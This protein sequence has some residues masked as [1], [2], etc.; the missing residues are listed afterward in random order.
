MLCT[1]YKNCY[2]KIFIDDLLYRMIHWFIPVP[3]HYHWLLTTGDVI[4]L[5]IG[6]LFFIQNFF[7]II[8][9][10]LG[11]KIKDFVLFFCFNFFQRKKILISLLIIKTQL[12]EKNKLSSIHPF[13][14]F[15]MCV[16]AKRIPYDADVLTHTHFSFL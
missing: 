14:S 16:C 9:G 10:Y 3:H 6:N 11:N 1:E 15:R 2:F 8:Q 7:K 4:I 13:Y 12:E 5:N